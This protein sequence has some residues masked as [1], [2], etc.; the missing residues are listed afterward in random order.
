MKIFPL[1]IYV[2]LK[3]F[4]QILRQTQKKLVGTTELEKGNLRVWLLLR[5]SNIH[6]VVV[7]SLLT[8]SKRTALITST[9][10]L[11]TNWYLKYHLVFDILRV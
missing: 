8:F 9:D 1:T 6:F 10:N 4:I 7:G 5:G 2:L 3:P 11:Y